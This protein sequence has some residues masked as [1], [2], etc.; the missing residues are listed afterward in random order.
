MKVE[1]N[2]IDQEKNKY[3]VDLASPLDIS[4]PI[5]PAIQP[6]CYQAPDLYF[7]PLRAGSFVGS[8]RDGATVN[9][10]NIFINPHGSTTYTEC[11]GH[12][13]DNNLFVKDV[14]TH[15][16]FNAQLISFYPEETTDGDFI[17]G[18]NAVKQLKERV[19]KNI[20]ALVIRTLPNSEAKKSKDYSQTNPPYL[21]SDF[22]QF[23]VDCDIEH[24]LIDMPSVDR[25]LDEGNLLGH[26]AFW[27]SL[28]RR[29]KCT[30]TEMIYVANDI[31][32]DVYLLQLNIL[33]I[34]L[35]VSPSR[36][37]LYKKIIRKDK[38]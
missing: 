6:K 12:I 29:K 7:E 38:I 15:S 28:E 16:F 19:A 34:C 37:I 22:I 4:I 14:L 5:N 3:S 21:R 17:L 24:L 36:P 30:I 11:S 8:I 33:A 25:E 9:F 13:F 20:K 35:D 32:D 27:N 10:F 18:P 23:I 1:I 31:E 26:R 2:F